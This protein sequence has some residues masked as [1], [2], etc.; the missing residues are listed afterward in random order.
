M[1]W[2]EE[3]VGHGSPAYGTVTA[4][5]SGSLRCH[6]N[7]EMGA[8]KGNGRSLLSKGTY[9]D[10]EGC[11]NSHVPAAYSHE[12]W[13]RMYARSQPNCR[14]VL[15]W[16]TPVPASGAGGF[17]IKAHTLA[18]CLI[19]IYQRTELNAAREK[20][21]GS[22][23]L[24]SFL[25][26][27]NKKPLPLLLVSKLWGTKM[28][29]ISSWCLGYWSSSPGTIFTDGHLLVWQHAH[30][31]YVCQSLAYE[32]PKYRSWPTK[33]WACDSI[34]LTSAPCCRRVPTEAC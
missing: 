2:E 30:S 12:A 32:D 21:F 5:V 3:K 4:F 7:R 11:S 17:I 25:V 9:S 33:L 6:L 34:S 29:E 13:Q 27:I 26:W 14:A 28:P 16:E 19:W 24:F 15:D 23:E 22:D 8:F 10:R 31:H 18:L 20:D 1:A